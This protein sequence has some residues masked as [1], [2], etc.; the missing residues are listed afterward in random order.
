MCSWSNHILA[1]M[2]SVFIYTCA[3]MVQIKLSGYASHAN[4][5]WRHGQNH[6]SRRQAFSAHCIFL[7]AADSTKSVISSVVG[8]IL[9]C[10]LMFILTRPWTSQHSSN[11][12]GRKWICAIKWISAVSEVELCRIFLLRG[13]HWNSMGTL[14]IRLGALWQSSVT[15]LQ[16]S[17]YFYLT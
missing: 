6:I 2:H 15:L 14:V 1:A 9:Y 10:P 17:T 5:R 13:T 4:T 7:F 12:I 16:F 11:V 3:N 8:V